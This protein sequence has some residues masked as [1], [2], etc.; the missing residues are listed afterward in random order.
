MVISEGG[1][2][3]YL[4]LLFWGR[5]GYGPRNN[6]LGF[7]DM[8]VKFETG[9]LQCACSQ[10]EMD[11]FLLQKSIKICLLQQKYIVNSILQHVLIGLGNIFV[12]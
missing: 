8:K 6:F 10:N 11:L 4:F 2:F 1:V 9:V 7:C 5:S 3:L 12:C